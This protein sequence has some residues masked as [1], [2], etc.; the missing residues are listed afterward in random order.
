MN[1]QAVGNHR[2]MVSFGTGFEN[3][4]PVEKGELDQAVKPVAD[5][6]P[7]G[8][9]AADTGEKGVIRLLQYTKKWQFGIERYVQSDTEPRRAVRQVGRDGPGAADDQPR[10]LEELR[11]GEGY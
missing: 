3:I 4:K 2:E 5:V 6:P 1:V 8:V 7:S 11:S 9:E 10:C